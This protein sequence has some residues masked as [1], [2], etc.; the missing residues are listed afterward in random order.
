M[1]DRVKPIWN[2]LWF[3]LVLMCGVRALANPVPNSGFEEGADGKLA[4]WTL[5]G[6]PVT[7]SG[8]KSRDNVTAR[9]GSQRPHSGARCLSLETTGGDND[10]GLVVSPEIGVLPQGRRATP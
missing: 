8:V 2:L 5:D 3:W 1:A 6:Q 9:C 7:Q 4:A 10:H